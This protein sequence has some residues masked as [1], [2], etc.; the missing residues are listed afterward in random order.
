[1]FYITTVLS[2]VVCISCTSEPV[3]PSTPQCGKIGQVY[4]PT[5]P[6]NKKE[7]K[8]RGVQRRGNK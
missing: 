8:A 7:V 6:K 3:I 1:M 5:V 4:N 2:L